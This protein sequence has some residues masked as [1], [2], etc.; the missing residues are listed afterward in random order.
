[1]KR[2]AIAAS[3]RGMGSRAYLLAFLLASC[4][5]VA[6]TN[7]GPALPYY[8]WGACP[9]ECCTYRAWTTNDDVTLYDAIG[10]RTVVTTAAVGW[11]KETEKFDHM[12]ACE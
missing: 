7:D 9:F 1:M 4:A 5:T 11:S 8:D 10:S 6:R 12:D 3:T 2:K